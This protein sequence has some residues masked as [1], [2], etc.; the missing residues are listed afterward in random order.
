MPLSDRQGHIYVRNS[1]GASGMF[2]LAYRGLRKIVSCV[3]ASGSGK[4]L[5]FYRKRVT[6]I[7]N[8]LVVAKA[9]GGRET[10]GVKVWG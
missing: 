9:K 2:V 3:G 5:S 7:K 10:V 8:R 6:G 4:K 1:V